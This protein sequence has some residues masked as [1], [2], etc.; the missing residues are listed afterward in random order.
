L[1]INGLLVSTVTM[2]FT[3]LTSADPFTIGRMPG[4]HAAHVGRIDEVRV[5]DYALTDEQLIAKFAP[6]CD[7][8]D[9]PPFMS[10]PD[11]LTLEWG[12]DPSPFA[13]NAPFLPVTEG[14]AFWLD[15]SESSTVV[16][17]GL[18][19]VTR[20]DDKSIHDPGGMFVLNGDPS[21]HP[22]AGPNGTGVVRFDG[23][24]EL[25]TNYDLDNV[26]TEFTMF[27]VAR[28]TA[29]GN[30]DGGS[31]RIIDSRD[32]NWLFGFW[33]A[34]HIRFFANGWVFQGGNDNTDWHVHAGSINNSDQ[35][36]FWADGNQY[37]FDNNG[38]NDVFPNYTP[39][40][41]RLGGAGA[42]NS[43]CEVAE[44][45]VFDRILT[46]T[47]RNAVGSYLKSKYGLDA[48][49]FDFGTPG[50]ARA[51]DS[52]TD[53]I[54]SFSDVTN[55]VGPCPQVAVIS[56]TWSATDGVHV[57]N[58]V[59]TITLIDTLEPDLN[60]PSDVTI[61]CALVANSGV[62][63]ATDQCDENPTVEFCDARVETVEPDDLP[64][65]VLW[66]DANQLG[67]ANGALITSWTDASGNGNDADNG[68]GGTFVTTSIGGR[69]AVRFNTA[70]WLYTTTAFGR[71]YTILHVSRMNGGIN[72]RLVSA[73]DGNRLYGWWNGGR[74]QLYMEGSYRLAANNPPAGT[75]PRLYAVTVDDAGPSAFYEDGNFIAGNTAISSDMGRLRLNG[76]QLGGAETSD[77]D[78]AEVL[79]FNRVLN[80]NELDRMGA[81]LTRKYDLNT[82]YPEFNIPN[83]SPLGCSTIVRTWKAWDSCNNTNEACQ[84]ITVEDD[85]APVITCPDDIT[86]E[87]D[88]EGNEDDFEDWMELIQV[89]DNCSVTTTTVITPYSPA[90]TTSVGLFSDSSGLDLSGD[91]VY[92]VNARGPAVGLIGD[93]NFTADT[94]PGVTITAPNNIL[95]WVTPDYDAGAGG[96]GGGP[97]GPLETVM[98]SI[99]WSPNPQ[100][101]LVD[102]SLN[103]KSG[104][105]YKLQ[106]LFKENA[107]C[108]AR[109]FDISVEGAQ[110]VDDY[111]TA[112]TIPVGV[113]GVVTHTFWAHDNE[114]NIQLNGANTP[115]GDKNPILNGLTLE[116]LD[117]GQPGSVVVSVTADD[118]CHQTN[119][120]GNFVI[121]D[122]APPEITCPAD[123]DVE[124]D[125]STDPS[126]TGTA[127]ADDACFGVT[128]VTSSDLMTAGTCPQQAT[129]TRTWTTLDECWNVNVCTQIIN[130]VDTTPPAFIGV[131]GDITIACTDA[132]PAVPEVVAED[133][134]GG[135]NKNPLGEDPDLILWLDAAEGITLDGGGN[136]TSWADQSPTGNDANLI[137]GEPFVVSDEINGRDVVRFQASDGLADFVQTTTAF[138]KPYTIITVSKMNGSLSRRLISSGSGGNNWLMGYWNGGRDR[139][140]ANGWVNIPGTPADTATHIYSATQEAGQTRFFEG[141]T[142]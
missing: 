67:L 135:F 28:Y 7:P 49:Y 120:T 34:S 74:Q 75:D 48:T 99:R 14:L 90:S 92:A 123:V 136:V 10:V 76:W 23:D 38:A 58:A 121:F 33:G 89:T 15:A 42:E 64:G 110:I 12:V 13:T 108:A 118:G 39:G 24:D 66:L 56:R 32:K 3:P 106:L 80:A 137:G 91:F 2:N 115:F 30:V 111:S 69:P 130:I 119:W 97:E 122:T 71:D 95:N 134:C 112:A 101:V 82:A 77:G 50:V 105:V 59:Q 125:D 81:Y 11:D 40:Q 41:L 102:L 73:A 131:P 44:V 117:C 43:A 103:V 86:V 62:A 29:S 20:W 85:Q 26:L 109:G 107:C 25:G 138:V 84:F 63:T 78:V 27:S 46:D 47:E 60:L 5:F 124:C 53:P 98:Q 18:G 140:F 114:V 54:V 141:G 132:N 65:L 6:G 21:Y 94:T 4:L 37:A 116:R 57:T 52:C 96:S 72:R 9:T 113:G 79:I 127:T 100:D 83:E 126:N 51:T 36:N 142:L 35:A 68:P 104:T 93:A 61:D 88:G 16:A 45:L 133:A 128:P 55:A 1:Y 22:A 31:R 129:L 87:C 8:D 17:D 70:Q 139:M 19:N